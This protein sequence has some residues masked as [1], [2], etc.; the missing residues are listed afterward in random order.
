MRNEKII[1]DMFTT[2]VEQEIK[3]SQFILGNKI[4]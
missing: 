1:Y 4:I 3:R 2:A